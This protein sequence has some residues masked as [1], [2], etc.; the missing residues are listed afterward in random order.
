MLPLASKSENFQSISGAS[1]LKV[2]AGICK[3][4]RSDQIASRLAASIGS[5]VR[6]SSEL[7]SSG[8]LRFRNRIVKPRLASRNRE[9][10]P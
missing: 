8:E 1:A 10:N 6:W 3:T 9:A 2:C 7:L 5:A 4:A